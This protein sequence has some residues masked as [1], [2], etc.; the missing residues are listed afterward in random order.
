VRRYDYGAHQ[1]VEEHVLVPKPGGRGE[2]DAWLL[3][4]TF[5]AR[6]QATVLNL[7]DAA[8]IEDGPVAQAVLPYWL[9]L[10][11]HGNFTSA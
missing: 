9:P 8:H 11:F 1:I 4:T 6:R 10:G 3:G 5:D 2:L 7:L